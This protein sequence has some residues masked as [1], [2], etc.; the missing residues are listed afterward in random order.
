MIKLSLI[1]FW[2][3]HALWAADFSITMDDPNLYNTPLFT[4]LERDFKILKQLDQ[5]K[6]KAALFVCG[7]RVDSQDGIELLK[8]WDAKRHLIGNHTYSHPY[9]HSSAL[10]FEDFAKDFLK[11]E[12]QISHLTHFTRVFRFPFLKSGN[13][14]EKRNKIRELLRDKGYRHGYVT[15]DASDWYISERL[16]SKLKQNPNF[17]IAGY[18]DFY[19]QHMWDRA[20]YYDGLAQKVLGRSPKHTM[21][22]HHNL[23]NALFLNDLIQFF[24][25]KGW[26][27]IDAEEAL[28][29]PLF[30]L[31]PDNL[32]SGE[33]I[34]WALAKE[35][36]IAGLRYPAEDS[37]YEEERMNQLGL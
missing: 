11:V 18:K 34:I 20:Q 25:Q 21:L 32:P 4:P 24:K 26:N 5:N 22:I 23:L 1:F 14:V 16:E 17:K 35:K 29:D 2:I 3:S 31:E 28:R 13:T 19:L 30:S 12:P 9:Y 36:K 27:L 33:G 6:I 15:I 10:S 7:K 37:V 8:R